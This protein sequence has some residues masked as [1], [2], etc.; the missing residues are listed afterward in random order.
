MRTPFPF[1]RLLISVTFLLGGSDLD[2]AHAAEREEDENTR[3]QRF[4][5]LYE[6]AG[7]A[8][9]SGN[10]TAAIPSLQAAYALQ[11]LPPLLF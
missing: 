1:L 4:K 6:S 9:G 11:P 5:E 10:Y 3:A 2:C 8:Y 7:R